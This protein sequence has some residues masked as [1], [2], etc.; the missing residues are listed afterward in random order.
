[1]NKVYILTIISKRMMTY[2][3][4]N[5]D[6]NDGSEY[7]IEYP[8]YE[9]EYKH[10]DIYTKQTNL[11][12]IHDNIKTLDKFITISDY[13]QKDK[14]GY[15][16][17]DNDHY[18]LEKYPLK[19]YKTNMFIPFLINAIPDVF[20]F[21]FNNINFGYNKMRI[22]FDFGKFIIFQNIAKQINYLTTKITKLEIHDNIKSVNNL[23]SFITTLYLINN[24]KLSNLPYSINTL[25]FGHNFINSY[26]NK[27]PNSINKL[28]YSCKNFYFN[29]ISSNINEI[30]IDTNMFTI[31]RNNFNIDLLPEGLKI[32]KLPPRFDKMI[33]DLPSSIEEIWI[34]NEF[35]LQFIN[36]MYQNKVNRHQSR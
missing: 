7:C 27:L 36:K 35:D 15:N 6:K 19:Y 3:S 8:E 14:Y 30:H 31:D 18:N 33:N 32:I 24:L 25:S 17:S 12:Y 10:K 9:Y 13:Y 26:Q 2:T 34:Y 20:S 23:S 5:F 29:N 4:Y 21:T 22:D 16:F 11:M 28:I 1:M